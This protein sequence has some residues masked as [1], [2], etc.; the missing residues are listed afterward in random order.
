MDSRVIGGFVCFGTVDFLTYSVWCEVLEKTMTTVWVCMRGM[1]CGGFMFLNI[2]LRLPPLPEGRCAWVC[3]VLLYVRY[4]SSRLHTPK[5]FTEETLLLAYMKRT[6]SAYIPLRGFSIIN[7]EGV[8]HKAHNTFTL[9]HVRK[10]FMYIPL[11][12][13]LPYLQKGE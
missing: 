6:F 10:P 7:T 13:S 1:C 3:S 2:M 11:P 9:G 4:R 5:S 12:L 8:R